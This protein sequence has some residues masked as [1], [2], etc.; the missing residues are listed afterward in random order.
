LQW[1]RK[2]GDSIILD[3]W[4]VCDRKAGLGAKWKHVKQR[5]ARA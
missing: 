3:R 2:D 4:L 1:D 5:E